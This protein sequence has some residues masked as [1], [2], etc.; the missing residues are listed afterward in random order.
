VNAIQKIEPSAA[1]SNVIA[2]S[3]MMEVIARAASD[4]NTD[5]TKLERLMA[6]AERLEAKQASEAFDRAMAAAQKEMEPVRANASN[7]QTRSKYASY[8]AL[9]KAIRPI[10][11]K[12]GFAISYD[13]GDG[14][15]DHL[16]VLAHVSHEGGGSRDFKI[17]M[18]ADGKGAKGGD[19]MTKTHAIGSAFTY[20]K[21]YQLGGIFNI[22]VSDDD[23]GNGASGNGPIT[24][25]QVA[26]IAEL[27]DRFDADVP[28]FCRYMGVTAV[29]DIP[30]K[31]YR[32][33][34]ESL[35]LKGKQKK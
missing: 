23:D 16:R 33:A 12:H 17:D 21:R 24:D 10:Y 22:V 26:T 13:T 3:S 15:P 4:P 31:S 29:K 8:L 30:A 34:I 35:N 20:G 18:P 25:E 32:K 19:V 2:A 9:D 28:A 1:P 5:V 11:S 14:P 27:M 6:M 7:P